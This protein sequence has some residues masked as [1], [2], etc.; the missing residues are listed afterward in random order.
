MNDEVNALQAAYAKL[1]HDAPWTLYGGSRGRTGD[2]VKDGESGS[3]DYGPG[4][5]IESGSVDY[6]EGVIITTTAGGTSSDPN[7]EIHTYDPGKMVD[8]DPL[9]PQEYP[10][11]WEE[12]KDVPTNEEEEIM[13]AGDFKLYEVAV[14]EEPT[15]HAM[16]AG[17]EPKLVLPPTAVIA[18]EEKAA[19]AIATSNMD[20]KMT[21]RTKVL[22]RGFTHGATVSR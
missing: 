6:G 12:L 11:T 3:V 17:E 13:F 5:I 15:V 1:Y 7:F 2:M 8:A 22:V 19:I 21:S 10:A 9:F 18:R 14:V 16:E 20:A 4:V